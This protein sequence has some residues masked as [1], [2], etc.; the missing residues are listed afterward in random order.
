[1]ANSNHEILILGGGFV[2]LFTALHLERLNCECPRTL[3]DR[4]WRFVFK[5]LLYELLSSETN[6]DIIWPRYDAL[7]AERVV[8]FVLDEI[9]DI[10]LNNKQVTTKT[11]LT[12]S[13]KYLV[14]G[15]GATTGYFDIPGTQEHTLPFRDGRDTIVLGEHLRKTL[16]VAA[17]RP[18]KR[19]QN[20]TF[21]IAGAGPAGVELAVTLA[22][23][24]PEWYEPLGG[25]PADINIVIL[26]RGEEILSG[27]GNDKL[28][29]AARKAMKKRGVNLM[30]GAT[31]TEIQPDNVIY[32]QDGEV[33]SLPASTIVW[34]AGT[35][36]N[37]LIKNLN[38]PDEHKDRRGKLRVLP[39]LQ[40]PG[41]PEVFAAGDCALNPSDDLPDTAQVAYQQGKAIADNIAA[42]I[43]G[44]A[45]TPA[46]VS[47]RG[48]L[49]KLGKGESAAEIF[50]KIEIKG[51]AGHLIREATYLSILPLPGY[52][53]KTG[54]QW[55]TEEV[56]DQFSALPL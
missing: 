39:T 1:M 55:L 22:D 10:D 15:L 13:Y 31:V 11:G 41:H 9:S 5:P 50:D 28:K 6:V 45:P 46:E 52:K 29:K 51:H 25:D 4:N 54:V 56:F 16:Q 44:K 23:L 38:I 32:K 3:I 37:P 35:A 43:E 24:L 7:L 53:L 26:Q 19:Q 12:H 40:L 30:T 21:A 17:L 27:L 2:G 36:T 18:E 33:R 34:T 14:L 42:L 20:L 49:L 48:T 47:L 8:T